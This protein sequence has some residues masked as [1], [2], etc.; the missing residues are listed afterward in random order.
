MEDQPALAAFARALAAESF[1]SEAGA[2]ERYA[3]ALALAPQNEV[4]A[5][6]AL[7]SALTAGNRPLALR[8]ARALEAAGKV[9]P[10]A[11]LLLLGDAMQRRDWKDAATHIDTVEKD[12]VF[13]FLTPLL[14]VWLAQGSGKGDPLKL[15]EA[16]PESEVA[17]PY[18]AQQRPLILL[19]EGKRKEGIAALA[20]MLAEES[21]RAHRIRIAAAALLARKHRREALSL[22]EGNAPAIAAARRQVEAGKP[23]RGGISTPAEGVADF[24]LRFGADVIA[25][26]APEVALSFSRLAGIIAPGSSD[27]AVVTSELLAAKGAHEA[28]LAVLS[29]IPSDDPLASEAEARRFAAL[30]ATGR[31]AEAA[32]RAQAAAAAQPDS[33]EAQAALGDILGQTKQHA[34]A[35]EAYQ[36]ALVLAKQGAPTLRSEWSLWLLAGSALLQAER[37]P[38]AKTSLEQAYKL[39]PDHPI[40][41]NFLGY[42]QLERRENVAEATRLIEQASKLQP[43]NAGI[44]DSLGWAHFLNGNVPKAIELLEKATRGEPADAA[45][46][47]HLGDAYYVAGRRFE[48][49]YAWQ[50]ALTYAEGKVAE[51]LR[52]KI[53]AGLKPE[54]AAP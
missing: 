46:N 18:L 22:L 13:A 19:L 51:R 24:I 29:R 33:V 39:A 10:D 6:R 25:G 1:G 7:S 9:P 53:D 27:A 50:A 23:L 34:E 21:A 16:V 4:L 42:S 41:L 30:A 38:E 37:W 36:R 2:A 54:L 32:A 20:P 11:R 15:I 40:V 5:G 17:A 12:E 8:A 52:A 31:T 14:R 26:E 3:A 45:I 44:T 43:D 35:A 48:A 28:A 47:E 49:R